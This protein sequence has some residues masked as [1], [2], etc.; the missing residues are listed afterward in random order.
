MQAQILLPILVYI[1]YHVSSFI[2]HMYLIF[3]NYNINYHLYYDNFKHIMPILPFI[4]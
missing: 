2:L 4:T 3:T 1:I